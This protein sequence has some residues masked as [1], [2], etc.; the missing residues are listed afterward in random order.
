MGVGRK[1]LDGQVYA[2]VDAEDFALSLNYV[3]YCSHLVDLLSLRHSD[4]LH[5]THP[6]LAALGELVAIAI[7]SGTRSERTRTGHRRVNRYQTVPKSLKQ[8]RCPSQIPL[9]FDSL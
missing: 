7:L 1:P 8:S 3:S 4:L 2:T 6:E 5:F 9:S